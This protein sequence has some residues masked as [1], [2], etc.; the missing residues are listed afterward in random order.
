MKLC[1]KVCNR[2]EGKSAVHVTKSIVKLT[3]KST[4]CRIIHV[5]SKKK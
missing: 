4:N 3:G 5:E 1:T 2:C